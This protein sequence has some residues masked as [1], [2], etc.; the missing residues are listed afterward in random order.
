MTKNNEMAVMGGEDNAVSMAA[1]RDAILEI[2]ETKENLMVLGMPGIGKTQLPGQVAQE[3]GIGFIRIVLPQYEEVDMKGV[4]EISEKKKTVFYPA[5]VLPQEERDGKV[6]I[7]LIDEAPSAKPSVQV[8][9][10]ELM[11]SRKLGSLYELPEGWVIV[12]TGNTGDDGAYTHEIPTTVRT[13]CG[14]GVVALEVT[15]DE[16]CKWAQDTGRVTPEVIS[17]VKK[18]EFIDFDPNS[19]D[20][21]YCIPRTLESVS[22]YLVFCKAHSR[23]PEKNRLVGII[24]KKQGTKLYGWWKIASMVPDPDAIMAGTEHTVPESSDLQYCTMVTLISRLS[25]LGAEKDVV[26]K[27]RRVVAYANTMPND[28]AMAFANDLLTTA[29]WEKNRA[30]LSRSEEWL[31]FAAK[32]GKD[33]TV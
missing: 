6:G 23:A 18:N 26:V 8:I 22:K 2:L 16:W 4:P 24:G 17:Y 15:V 28:I 21:N 5:D 19:P 31:E 29:V 11:D 3:R 30:K 10:H 13:R 20:C 14:A 27:A 9:A 25:R 32:H 33:L 7:L 12:L 1:Y